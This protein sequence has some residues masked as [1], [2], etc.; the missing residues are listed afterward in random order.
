VF[1]ALDRNHTGFITQKD[2]RQAMTN[3]GFESAA[4][5][6][7]T[8]V[9]RVGYVKQGKINYSEFLV[10]Y[11]H[12]KKTIDDQMIYE[13]F[14]YFDTSNKGFL[15]KDD[16]IGVLRRNSVKKNT[17]AIN[18]IVADYQFQN[19]EKIGLEEFGNMMFEDASPIS[20]FP[21]P[22]M[23]PNQPDTTDFTSAV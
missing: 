22:F 13:T 20:N 23:M 4:R 11:L 9:K 3:L 12:M 8:I 21:T 5:E 6:I 17:T 16:I 10:A 14:N 7:K 2:L 1:L 18:E 15:T 19:P